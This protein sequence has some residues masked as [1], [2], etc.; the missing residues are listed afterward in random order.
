MAREPAEGPALVDWVMQTVMIAVQPLQHD[1]HDRD[2]PQIHARTARVM[3]G[4]G[5]RMLL[6]KRKQA[7]PDCPVAINPPKR[8]MSSD[9]TDLHGNIPI[10]KPWCQEGKHGLYA[11]RADT[12]YHR[13]N[14]IL[15]ISFHTIG[16]A[17]WPS[18]S[19][20]STTKKATGSHS[21]GKP[22]GKEA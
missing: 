19:K 16:A 18:T 21:S 17:T 1:A 3:A 14:Y 2:L 20:Q 7:R 5:S 6:R 12:I 15:A 4:M 9:G 11:F 10:P 13:D 22:S 8:A